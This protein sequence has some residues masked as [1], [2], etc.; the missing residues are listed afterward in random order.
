M[1]HRT[2]TNTTGSYCLKIVKRV[3]GHIIFTS[4]AANVSLQHERK[5]VDAGATSAWFRLLTRLEASSQFVD[6]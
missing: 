1:N 5:R 4:Y 2:A 6:I 3:I